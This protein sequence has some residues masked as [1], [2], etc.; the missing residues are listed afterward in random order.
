VL[1]G[2]RSATD[3]A[4]QRNKTGI[5]RLIPILSIEL[6]EPIDAEHPRSLA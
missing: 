2:R 4:S 1:R 3:R 5:L 6:F